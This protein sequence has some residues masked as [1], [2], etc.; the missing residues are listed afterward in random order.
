V[1]SNKQ[2]ANSEPGNIEHQTSARHP[3]FPATVIGGIRGQDEADGGFRIPKMGNSTSVKAVIS[4]E[5][6]VANF[7]SQIS[8][9]R[10]A[11][12]VTSDQQAKSEVRGP[13]LFNEPITGSRV[14]NFISEISDHRITETVTSDE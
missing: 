9:H 8:D 3:H 4:D 5:R 13:K 6:W 10:N 2:L 14:A 12:A 11:K 7:K 1:T